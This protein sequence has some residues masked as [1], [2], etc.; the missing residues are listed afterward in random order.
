MS[1]EYS[2]LDKIRE[3]SVIT[4]IEIINFMCAFGFKSYTA[5]HLASLFNLSSLSGVDT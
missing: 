3:K 2:F 4:F 5:S 1:R